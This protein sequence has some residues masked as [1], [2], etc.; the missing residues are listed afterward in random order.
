M[1]NFSLSVNGCGAQVTGREERRYGGGAATHSYL[2]VADHKMTFSKD[3]NMNAHVNE[4]LWPQAAPT[5]TQNLM[6]AAKCMLSL[7]VCGSQK[8]ETERGT[9]GKDRVKGRGG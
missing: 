5:T 4:S 7:S 3:I 8:T 1:Q 2:F 6:G 9:H